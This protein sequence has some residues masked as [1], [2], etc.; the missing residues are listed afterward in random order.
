MMRKLLI[1]ILLLC[2]GACF[3]APKDVFDKAD[4]CV[5]FIEAVAKV[6]MAMD[7]ET[8]SNEE[9][10]VATGVVTDSDGTI[11]TSAMVMDPTVALQS[12]FGGILGSLMKLNISY[13][14]VKVRFPNGDRADADIVSTDKDTDTAV[15]KVKSLPSGVVPAEKGGALDLFDDFIVCAKAARGDNSLAAWTCTVGAVLSKPRKMYYCKELDMGG[16][17]TPGNPVF[18]LD[19]KLVG[20]VT[21][22]INPDLT[23]D[24]IRSESM[25]ITAVN[26]L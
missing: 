21:T 26:P 1:L 16:K 7:S 20:F 10:I 22:Y 4:K 19:G 12:L 3:A 15:L 6:T 5:V 11:V 24:N 9:E 2:C 13:K 23:M 17:S 14:S 25:G 18:T 8:E